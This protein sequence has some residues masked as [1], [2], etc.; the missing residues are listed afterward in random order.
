[1]RPGNGQVRHT[2]AGEKVLGRFGGAQSAELVEAAEVLRRAGLA[3]TVVDDIHPHLWQKLA[4]NAGIN[5]TTALARVPNGE[6]LEQPGLRQ[7]ALTLTAEAV[8]VARAQGIDP[9][10]AA[11]KV[12]RVAGATAGNR[13]SMLVD[14]EQGR[15]TE[16]DAIHGVVVERGRQW[17]VATPVSAWVWA[18]LSA[19]R[20][21]ESTGT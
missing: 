12:L 10:D 9:G 5:A 11:E 19:E 6:I 2:G 1:M 21:W 20:T 14:W 17:G 18:I 4:V 13:S 16:V 7:A 8:A 3:T 15:R